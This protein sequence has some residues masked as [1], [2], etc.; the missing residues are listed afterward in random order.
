MLYALSSY[1]LP[2]FII[3]YDIRCTTGDLQMHTEYFCILQEVG[4]ESK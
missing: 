2:F 1:L 4:Q 3:Y